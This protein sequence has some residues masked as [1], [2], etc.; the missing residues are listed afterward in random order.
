[1]GRIDA[2]LPD[3]LE[4]RF[5]MEVAKRYGVKKGNMLKAISEAIESWV[6]TD[7]SRKMAKTLARAIRDPKASVSVKQHAVEALASTGVAGRELLADIGADSALPDSVR[8]QAFKAI[9]EQAE[10]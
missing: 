5:R 10:R 7:E 6:S 2:V 8:E 1:M 3:K 9:S 4:Q